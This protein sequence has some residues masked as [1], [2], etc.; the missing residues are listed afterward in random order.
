[1]AAVKQVYLFI[2]WYRKPLHITLYII[3]INF[4]YYELLYK[5][6]SNSVDFTGN[7]DVKI[8]N[9]YCTYRCIVTTRYDKAIHNFPTR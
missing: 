9:E 7:V 6:V 8:T 1:M 4:K 5:M 2:V 3:C